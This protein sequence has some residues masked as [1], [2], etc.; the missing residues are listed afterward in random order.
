MEFA[1]GTPIRPVINTAYCDKTGSFPESIAALLTGHSVVYPIFF[2]G[3]DHMEVL[4]EAS[5]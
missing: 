3:I 1:V 4:L 5:V 2:S